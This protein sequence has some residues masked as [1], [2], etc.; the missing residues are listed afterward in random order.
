M[1]CEVR[2]PETGEVFG[3][4]SVVRAPAEPAATYWRVQRVTQRLLALARGVI[5]PEEETGE[6]R[7]LLARGPKPRDE[8]RGVLPVARLQ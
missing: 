7:D 3:L 2:K 8:D 4:G 6:T 5:G 1:D